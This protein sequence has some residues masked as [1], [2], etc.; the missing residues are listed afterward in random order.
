MAAYS[1]KVADESGKVIKGTLTADDE[2]SA[3]RILQNKG[4]LPIQI[5]PTESRSDSAEARLA[6]WYTAISQRIS[7]KDVMVFTQDL[8]VLLGAGLPVDRALSILINA[9]EKDR[10]KAV[11]DDILKSVKAGAYLSD[12]MAK[13]PEAFSDFYINMVR[14]G[15]AGGVLEDILKRLGI[16]LETSQETKDYIVSAMIYPA[17]LA[18]ICGVSVIVLLA[19]VIPKFSVVFADMGSAIPLST[20]I[21]LSLSEMLKKGW[22]VIPIGIGAMFFIFMRYYKAPGGRL[23]VDRYT[24][25]LPLVGELVT[26]I[27][28][29]RFTRTLGV[30]LKSGVPILQALELVRAIIGN[31]FISNTMKDIYERVKEGDRFSHSLEDIS[32]LPTLG[33]QMILVGEESGRLDDMLIQVAQTYEKAVKETIK[34][35]IGLLEPMMILLMGLTVGFIVISMLMGIFSMNEIPF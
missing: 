15:E 7:S 35:L 30:L 33:V 5:Y 19:F 12:A 13:H 26:K 6:K 11:I 1:Y 2:K 22:W 20:T 32:I 8:A 23:K 31:R 28:T 9:I 29:A 25:R 3:A 18:L 16:F 34:R 24:L 10:F 21:L 17:F 27:E 14:A 4:Y